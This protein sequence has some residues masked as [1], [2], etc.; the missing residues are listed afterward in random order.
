M[1]P[2]R[3]QYPDDYV[4]FWARKITEHAINPYTQVLVAVVDNNDNAEADAEEEE[5]S[6]EK[7]VGIAIWERQGPSRREVRTLGWGA[8]GL[9]ACFFPLLGAF[10]CLTH[11]PP[12]S[13]LLHT[14]R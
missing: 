14:S 7:V 2:Y 12:P 13:L 8:R 10:F 11:F 5:A 3:H 4:A 1:H 9:L 6:E